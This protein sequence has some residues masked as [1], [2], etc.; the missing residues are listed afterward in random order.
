MNEAMKKTTLKKT[1]VMSGTNNIFINILL[2]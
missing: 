1:S 2:L